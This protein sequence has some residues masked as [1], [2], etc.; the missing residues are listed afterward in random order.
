MNSKGAS[1]LLTLAVAGALGSN[2]A[3]ALGP[4]VT[5]DYVLYAGGGSTDVNGFYVAASKILTNVDSYTDVASGA[6][7]TSYRVLF[8]TTTAPFTFNGTTIPAGK[9][10]LYF[11]K[12]NGGAYAN[13]IAPQIGTGSTLAYPTVASVQTATAIAGAVQNT[14]VPTY[15]FN[16]VGALTNLQIPDWGL[17]ELEVTMWQHFNNPTGNAGG[18]AANTDGGAAPHVGASSGIY[19]N[20]FGV[21]VT[22]NVYSSVSHPKTNFN[23]A[24][25]EGILAGSVSDWS[26]LYDDNG[27]QLPP[28]G[29]I[30]LDRGE[31][32]SVKVAGNQ[33]FLGYPGDGASAQLPYTANN[34]YTAT[35][36]TAAGLTQAAVD[37]NESSTV[38]VINDLLL[39]QKNNLRAIAIL[40]L[41][42]P[43]GQHQ[44]GGVN[45]FEITKINGVG[46]DTGTSGDN[47]NG[48]TATSY[49]NVVKGNYDFYYQNS[50]NTRTST[51]SGNTVGDVFANEFKAVFNS[52]NL[53]GAAS[54]L[55]FPSAVPGVLLDADT[56]GALAKGVVINT[57]FKVS[58]GPL[59][60]F[61]S[62]VSTGIP[63]SSDPL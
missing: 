20:L 14:G 8:G 11:Y 57:R 44:V 28:G 34:N 38:A 39:A 21:A 6:D 27:N 59:Q 9:N 43:P 62:A 7:S 49:I 48:T 52:S 51:L 24:E 41:E 45:Q 19:D 55:A 37:I 12:F 13:G 35:S 56:Q 26:Q 18:T 47:I 63:V 60:P 42:S 1:R 36:L 33:Y 22:E 10:V 29:I 31:G 23:R 25:I 15:Y 58:T 4:S 30:L 5:P 46:V 2:A 32:S 61:F 16:D 53:P 40:G 50:F 54:G 17:S 3:F